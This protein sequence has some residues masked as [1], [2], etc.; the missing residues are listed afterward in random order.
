MNQLYRINVNIRGENALVF[1][2]HYVLDDS[3]N[4][5]QWLALND[6]K[7]HSLWRS[8]DWSSRFCEIQ[9]GRG[10]ITSNQQL[11]LIPIHIVSYDEIPYTL[12][13]NQYHSILKCSNSISLS[14]T[15]ENCGRSLS[16]SSSSTTTASNS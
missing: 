2:G 15:I 9:V 13:Y 16:S 3:P 14:K 5:I 6:N 8:K 4:S 7:N 12:C 10:N 1:P 11:S